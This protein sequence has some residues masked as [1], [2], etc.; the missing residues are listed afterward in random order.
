MNIIKSMT[1]EELA[2]EL[3][4]EAGKLRFNGLAHYLAVV[5]ADNRLTHLEDL[6]FAVAAIADFDNGLTIGFMDGAEWAQM[7]IINKA[8]QWLRENAHF[9]VSDFTGTLDENK[10]TEDFKKVMEE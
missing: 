7:F 3:A 8:R 9:Y 6:D 1:R 4:A 10:L 5:N 2:K